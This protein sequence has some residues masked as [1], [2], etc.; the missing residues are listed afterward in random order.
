MQ[1][2]LSTM[3][4]AEKLDAMEQLW[5]SLQDDPVNETT[6]AWHEQV[7]DERR[8]RIESGE[9]KFYSLDEVRQRLRE[10]GA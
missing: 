8:K 9:A 2:P 3:T 10:H 6:P 1:L 4:T 7:L 5:T